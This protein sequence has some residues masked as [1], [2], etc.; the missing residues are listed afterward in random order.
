MTQNERKRSAL[1]VLA[2]GVAGGMSLADAARQ[3]NFRY[4]TARRRAADPAFRQRVEEL[5]QAIT[6][7]ALGRLTRD[8]TQAA[9]TFSA[10]LADPAPQVRLAAAKAI[11]DYRSRLR[12]DGEL[13]EKVDRLESLVQELVSHEPEQP[14]RQD[15]GHSPSAGG[16]ETES[17]ENEPIA[18]GIVGNDP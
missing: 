4:I 14:N 18:G 7:Q 11:L 10:L 3:A 8:M 16:E 5:R 13:R 12:A 9:D 17:E 15:A 6:D 2:L 1:E